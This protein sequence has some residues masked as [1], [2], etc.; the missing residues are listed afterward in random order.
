MLVHDSFP[1]GP[2]VEHLSVKLRIW[3]LLKGEGVKKENGF[4]KDP[5]LGF[6]REYQFELFKNLGLN[7]GLEQKFSSLKQFFQ[8]IIVGGG[9]IT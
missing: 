1:P 3:V 4:F 6:F 5:E 7:L 2:W 8:P 9:E